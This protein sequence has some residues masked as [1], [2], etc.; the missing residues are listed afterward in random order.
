MNNTADTENVFKSFKGQTSQEVQ[1]LDYGVISGTIY[2]K[3][4][5]DTSGDLYNDSL[6]FKVRFD[7]SGG[8]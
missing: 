6:Q 8:E 3:Y 2:A 4:I 1:T 7:Y 5:K